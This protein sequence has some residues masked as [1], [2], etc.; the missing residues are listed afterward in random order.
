MASSCS[1]THWAKLLP[2][3][4]SGGGRLIVVDAIGDE[5]RSFYENYHFVCV[6]NRERHLVMKVSTAT[7]A[8]GSAGGSKPFRRRMCY[9]KDRDVVTAFA[10]AHQ[11]ISD[12]NWTLPPA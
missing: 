5:A 3:R 4:K 12:Q 7:K 8:L 2:H 6:R 11:R 9:T 1:S 10:A